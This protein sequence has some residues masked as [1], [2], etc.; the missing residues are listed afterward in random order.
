LFESLIV[1]FVIAR[2]H[3][4]LARGATKQ[5]LSTIFAE[6]MH[7]IASGDCFVAPRTRGFT[8]P[9]NDGIIKHASFLHRSSNDVG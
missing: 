9:R 4:G 1:W 5:S 2:S 3:Q 6:I 8:A 7:E